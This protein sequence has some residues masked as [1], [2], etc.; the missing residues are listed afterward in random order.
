[1]GGR[2]NGAVPLLSLMDLHRRGIYRPS[3]HA[4]LTEP[5]IDLD[6]S[7]ACRICRRVL[8]GLPPGRR[9]RTRKSC[10]YQ[11][12]G[13]WNKVFLPA[14]QVYGPLSFRRAVEEYLLPRRRPN[15]NCSI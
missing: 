11:T 9:A 6:G 4:T 5:R 2:D 15:Y 13:L 12:K 3:R 10:G 7:V 1:M 8:A 14:M